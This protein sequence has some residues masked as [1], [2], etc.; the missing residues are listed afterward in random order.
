[1]PAPR[2]SEAEST[3]IGA[4]RAPRNEGKSLEQIQAEL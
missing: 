4:I 3:I 2:A 1:M